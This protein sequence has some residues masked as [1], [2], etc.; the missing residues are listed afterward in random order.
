M[1]D[2]DDYDPTAQINERMAD[3]VAVVGIVDEVKKEPDPAEKVVEKPKPKPVKTP[4]PE[5]RDLSKAEIE[6]L[7]KR[8]DMEMF[9]GLLGV[10]ME[11]DKNAG[12][13]PNGTVAE[14]SRDFEDLEKEVKEKEKAAAKPQRTQKPKKAIDKKVYDDYVEDEYDNY[15]D[16]YGDY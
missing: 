9:A 15:D 7:Q 4:K 5:A 11:K 1:W 8:G 13:K 6:E 12:E 2:D 16:K 14:Q 3:A 10:E